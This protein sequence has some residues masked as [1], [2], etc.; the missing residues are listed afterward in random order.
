MD[1]IFPSLRHGQLAVLMAESNTG[2]VLTLEGKVSVKE[3]DIVF[4]IFETIKEAH[5]YIREVKMLNKSVEF[6]IYDWEQKFIEL[7]DAG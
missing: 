1:L 6:C 7:I 2:Q 4:R 5:E 3:D